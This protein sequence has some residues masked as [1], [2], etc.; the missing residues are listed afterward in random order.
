MNQITRIQELQEHCIF[1]KVLYGN[2]EGGA[3]GR[4]QNINFAIDTHEALGDY[5]Q[6]LLKSEVKKISGET[7]N[8][9]NK[10]RKETKSA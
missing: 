10:K 4:E 7:G 3:P 2:V 1:L 9:G 8:G 5:K 6:L